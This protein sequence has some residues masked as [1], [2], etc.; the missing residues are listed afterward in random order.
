M[1]QL[2][3]TYLLTLRIL[4]IACSVFWA[5][6]ALFMAFYFVPAVERSGP[7]GG[8][9]TQA[10]MST[11]KLPVVMLTTAFITILSGILLMWELSFGFTGSW[12]TTKYGTTLTLGSVTAFLA[13]LLGFFINRPGAN[14]MKAIGSTLAKRGGPPLPEELAELMKIRSRVFLST[15]MIA[16]LL[17]VSIVTMGI[18]R[19]V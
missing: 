11:N 8:K 16:Y 4:H 2:M 7:D 19:Y 9:I 6:A 3:Y 13:F 17:L 5:G 1:D 15:R 10:I 12:F 14:R 18:A